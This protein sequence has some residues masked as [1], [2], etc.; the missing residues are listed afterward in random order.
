VKRAVYPG[1][2][3]ERTD[4]RSFN[5]ALSRF[6]Y[7]A[8]DFWV[9]FSLPST[10]GQNELSSLPWGLPHR[11]NAFWAATTERRRCPRDLRSPF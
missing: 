6:L 9:F 4:S 7:A 8:R 2:E 3:E 1:T 11:P 5:L 10:S